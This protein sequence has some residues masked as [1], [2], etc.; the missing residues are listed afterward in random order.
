MTCRIEINPDDPASIDRALRTEWLLTNGLGGYA[1]GTALG[2]N[3]RRYHG[4]LVA[5]TKPP[6]GRVVALHSMIEQLVIPRDDGSEEIID[7]STQMFVGPDCEPMMHPGGWRHLRSFNVCSDGVYWEW[8]IGNARASRFV[9]VLP[10]RNSSVCSYGV[11][12]FDGSV[13]LRVRPFILLRDFHSLLT[14]WDEPKSIAN[15]KRFV[16]EHSQFRLAINFIKSPAYFDRTGMTWQSK[17]EWWHRFAYAEDRRRDQDWIEDIWSP[18]YLETEPTEV[19]HRQWSVGL[20]TTLTRPKHEGKGVLDRTLEYFTPSDQPPTDLSHTKWAAKDFV[21]NRKAKDDSPVSVIAGYPWFGDWGRDAM[22]SLP[23]LMLCTGRLEEARSCLLLYARHV[24]NGL[25][26]NFFD[27]SGQGAHYNSVDASLWFVHAVRELRLQSPS[28]SGRGVRGEGKSA[29][30]TKEPDGPHPQPFSQREKGV[31]GSVKRAGEFVLDEDL[32][33]FA[34]DLRKQQTDAE[35]LM[36]GLLRDRRLLGMKFRR[37]HPIASYVLDFYCHEARLA[38]ELDGGQHREEANRRKDEA[39]TRFLEGRGIRVLRYWDHEVLQETEAVLEAIVSALAPLSPRQQEDYAQRDREQDALTP[40]PSPGGRGEFAEL[41]AACRAIVD[42]YRRGTDFKIFMDEDGLIAAGDETTQLTWMDAKRD[43]VVFT[44]RHGKAVEINALWISA[45]GCLGE[46]TDSESER[47][48]V[49]ALR[50]K[51]EEAFR[52][53]FWWEE[54][55]CLHDVL[56]PREAASGSGGRTYAPDGKVRPNQ[57]LAVSLPFSPLT[58]DQQRAVVKIVGER[59]LTPYGLRT[60]DRD[61]PEYR[62]R[63]EGNMFERDRAYHNGTV[64]PWLIGPYCEAL[65]RVEKFSEDAKRKVRAVLGPLLNELDAPNGGCVGQL[66][67]IYDG[68]DPQRPNGCPAQAWS[69]AEVLR[70]LA[71]IEHQGASTDGT[72]NADV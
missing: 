11:D 18:G 68:D 66:A 72:D 65:L 35:Q 26:P 50:R 48:E 20:R 37:Q 8:Q 46:M 34:R 56:R 42:A 16:V 4:L 22:I 70:V 64:W 25:I 61:N 30:A 32:L 71:M 60:L 13:R 39:R 69:V 58:E 7:L 51:A 5:A 67:E 24:R 43:G 57:I 12:Q 29:T 52:R 15:G 55:G 33:A 38:V 62:G 53:R 59:L 1:M 17:P 28:P 23:G 27:D 2:V 41:V 31:G 3:T 44:P 47:E 54:R 21:V 45:L 9:A 10:G 6:V 36:W 49:S 63:Y 14:R 40:D 19:V